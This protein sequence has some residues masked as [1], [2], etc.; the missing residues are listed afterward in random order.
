M[1][2]LALLRAGIYIRKNKK[3]LAIEFSSYKITTADGVTIHCTLM[4]NNPERCVIIAHPFGVGS[5]YKDIVALSE[6][7][8]DEFS[9]VSFDFRGHGK[10]GGVYNLGFAGVHIDMKT[11]LDDVRK[12]DFKKV[13]IVGFSLGAAAAL[14]CASDAIP[15]DA[16]VC[17]GCPP[18]LPELPGMHKQKLIS[19]MLLRMIGVRLGDKVEPYPSPE[20]IASILPPIPKFFIFGEIEVFPRDV[21]ETFYSKV[22]EPKEI[23]YAPG[24]WHASLEGNEI[25]IRE[26]LERN[27]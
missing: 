19:R 24:A 17:V 13:A 10:S 5:M 3:K 8:S 27:L 1:R 2:M 18:R 12:R 23:L 15:V 22:S 20:E 21:I 26:W 9:V 4:G 6:L 11:V 25:L 16:L 14:L 7:L